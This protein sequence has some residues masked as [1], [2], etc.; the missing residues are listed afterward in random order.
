MVIFVVACLLSAYIQSL[1]K[2]TEDQQQLQRVKE[3]VQQAGRRRRRRM[4][5]PRSMWVREW[6]SKGRRQQLGHY[7]MFLARALHTED[8]NT[9]QNYLTMPPELFDEVLERVTR[10][11]ERQ[12]TRFCSAL[13][14]GLKLSATL[15]QLAT[16]DNYSSLFNTFYCGKAAICRM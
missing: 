4:R 16:G 8:V 3:R 12:G 7:A 2:Q 11:I 10:A 15:R 1:H 13:P 5:R 14:P 9:F 6:L